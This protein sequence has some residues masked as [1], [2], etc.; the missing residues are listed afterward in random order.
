MSRWAI[1]IDLGGTG[2]KAAV[3]GKKKGI[4]THKR[5]LTDT[6]SGPMGIVTQLEAIIADLYKVASKT[7]DVS[8]F[9]GVG[10]GAPG[11]VDA[12]NGVLSYPP[13]LP[14]WTVFPLRDELQ[15]MLREKDK[16]SISVLLDNDANVA[17]FGEAIY[18]AGRGFRDF[19][20]V[21]LGT[22]VGG[23]IILNRKLYRGSHGTAGEVGFMIIDVDGPSL[24]AGIRGTL[25]SLIGKKAIVALACQMID[26]SPSGSSAGLL[27]DYDY[28]KLSPRH[29]QHAARDG[30]AVAL[31]VWQR[32][33]SLLGVGLANVT[34]LMDIRKFVIGGGIAAAGNLIFDPALDQLRRSTL[35]S[36]HEGL[37]LVPAHLGN[38]AGMYGAAA[39]C[40]G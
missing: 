32:V 17:A 10:V 22:G 3:I 2:I 21:T 13:N 39:L 12:K 15:K 30:D 4:L 29:L 16:L 7:L 24:H 27:C 31:A 35:P 20:M 19:L 38:K 6:T 18:G 28:T 26:A 34:A 11:A 40:F 5:I 14:G 25:E 33:G 9:A 1:G 36:M 8:D 23:G 37:E